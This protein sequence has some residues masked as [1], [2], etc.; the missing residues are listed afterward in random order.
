MGGGVVRA[1]RL[2]ASI[3]DVADRGGSVSDGDG[4]GDGHHGGEA[5]SE[6]SE[7]LLGDEG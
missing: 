4:A 1:L 2:Q 5:E 6:S 7:E 3:G